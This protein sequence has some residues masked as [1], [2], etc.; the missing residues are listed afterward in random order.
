MTNNWNEHEQFIQN[1]STIKVSLAHVV[2]VQEVQKKIG[3]GEIKSLRI[4]KLFAL[5]NSEYYKT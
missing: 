3:F 1:Q 4:T 2:S 5:Q